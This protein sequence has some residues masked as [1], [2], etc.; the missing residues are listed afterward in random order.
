MPVYTVHAPRG[1]GPEPF[2]ATDKFEFVRD[3]F[4][5]WAFVAGLIWLI[6]HRLWWALLGYVVLSI[7]GEVAL[8]MLKVDLGARFVVM[9]LFALLMGFE[10]ASLRRWTLSRGKWR[11]LDVVVADNKDAAERRFF[12]RWTAQHNAVNDQWA[13][14]RGGPPPTRHAPGQAFSRPPSPA[15][16]DIIG[17]FPQPGVTR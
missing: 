4:H 9:L 6:Y 15:Q 2:A 5:F 10:A 1:A 12:D 14:D 13:S 16:N 3:G 7:A 11:Q 17:L 8:S